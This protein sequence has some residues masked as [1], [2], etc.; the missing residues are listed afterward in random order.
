MELV[1]IRGLPGSGK[2]TPAPAKKVVAKTG[3]PARDSQ[4]NGPILTG[5]RK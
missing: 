4:K 2:T 3:F 5:S 1:L